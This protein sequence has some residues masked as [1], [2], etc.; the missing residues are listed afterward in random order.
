MPEIRAEG[1]DIDARVIV[2]AGIALVLVIVCVA[3]ASYALLSVW[4]A[5]P[6]GPNAPLDF[7]VSGAALESAPQLDRAQFDAE[8]HRMIEEYGWVDRAGG[9]AR[10]PVD[11]AMDTLVQRD[12]GDEKRTAQP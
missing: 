5:K 6:A 8:K 1:A 12:A 7:T 4:H 10:I 3:G 9:V 2:M 11:A